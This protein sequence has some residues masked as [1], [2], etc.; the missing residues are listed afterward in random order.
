MTQKSNNKATDL[1]NLSITITNYH[2]WISMLILYDSFKN[3]EAE[4]QCKYISLR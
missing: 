1:S 4:T 2:H 3:A